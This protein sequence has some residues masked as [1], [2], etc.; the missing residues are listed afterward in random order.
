MEKH[1]LKTTISFDILKHFYPNSELP[2][3]CMVLGFEVLFY[4]VFTGQNHFKVYS[5]KFDLFLL[6]L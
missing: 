1:L 3:Q 2:V 5:F 6:L 4:F